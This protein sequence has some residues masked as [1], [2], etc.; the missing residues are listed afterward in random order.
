MKVS[1]V[2]KSFAIPVTT[3]S[4]SK[5]PYCFR[6]REFLIISYETDV[7]ALRAVVPEPLELDLSNGPIVKYEFINMPDSDGFGSYSESG[8]VIPVTLN[9]KKGGYV[10]LMFLDDVAA[11]VG[12]REVWGFPKKYAHPEFRVDKI[13]K[14]CYIGILKYGELEVAR[15]TMGYKYQRLDTKPILTS[16]EQNNFLL[17]VIPDVDGSPKLCQLVQYY[18]T[19][20]KVKEAWTGPCSLQLFAHALAPVADLPIKRIIN[21]VHFKSDLTIGPGTVVFDYLKQK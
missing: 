20:L 11:T 1:E 9:K 12:G 3:P 16:L 2:K 10:H 19:D 4:F 21:G 5:G 15:A 13:N 6:D 7:D 17:K 14:D 8:Q 18:L